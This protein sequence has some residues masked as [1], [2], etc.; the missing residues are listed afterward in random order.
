[1]KKFNKIWKTALEDSGFDGATK[2]EITKDIQAMAENI[3]DNLLEDFAIGSEN[4]Q[5]RIAKKYNCMALHNAL[6]NFFC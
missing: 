4:T 5:I 1:M 6:N 2:T 3:P